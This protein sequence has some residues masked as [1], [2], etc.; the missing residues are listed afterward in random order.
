MSHDKPKT[1]AVL[2]LALA[3]CATTA[4][5]Q[6]TFGQ[7]RAVQAA[8]QPWMNRAL[9][10]DQRA[11][12]VLKELTLDEKIQMVHGSGRAPPASNGG[13][14]YVPGVKRLGL[15]DLNSADST[16]GVTGGAA[17]SRYSTLMPS[18]LAAAASWDTKAAYDYGA[19]IGRELRAQGY[20]VSLAGG[21]NIMR[22][23]RNGRSFEYLAEDPI[24]SGKLVGQTIRG[25]QDQKI[26]GDIKHYAVND[27]E[28]GRYTGSV[29]LD[30][31]SLRESDL[32][33]F[34][35]GVKEGQPGMAMCSYNRVNGDWACEN[36]YLLN[37]TLKRDW[38][39]KG[40]VISD[41]NGTH[42]TVKAALAGLDQQQPGADFF[43]EP[44]KQ[45]AQS[46]PVMAARVDDMVRRILRSEFATG[47]VDEP[48][49][50]Q[51]VDV[52]GGLDI[53][54]RIATVSTVLLK[55]GGALP[56]SRQARSIVV[57][58]SHADV[59]VLT[60]GGSA[61]V[62]PPGGN[63]APPAPGTPL[64]MFQ[65]PPVWYPSSPLKAMRAKATAT[66]LSYLSGADVAAAAA[67]AARADLAVVFANQPSA[68]GADHADLSL[69]DNQDALIAAVAAANPRTVVVL[70]TGGPVT[71]PWIDKVSAVVEAWYPGA[72]GGEAIADLLFA[73]ANFSARLPV[74]FPRAEADLPNPVLPGST[75]KPEPIPP[76]TPGGPPR[77][78][79]YPLFDIV[80]PEKANVGYKWYDATGKTPLF[81]FGHGLSYT[82]FGYSDLTV[83]Q[84]HVTF[85]VKNTGSR[86]GE[87]TAQV[88][89]RVPDPL[90][91]PRRLVVWAK[92]SLQPGESKTVTV[93]LEALHLSI[94]D[95]KKHGWRMPAGRYGVFVGASSRD[96][97]LTGQF[98][99]KAGG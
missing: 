9:S 11:D 13:A 46:D 16:V 41:W 25:L 30:E 31:R 52:M 64:D 66:Q 24:L 45:A 97:P 14:G 80:Y 10:A 59:G 70:E 61:Q 57:I 77:R 35:I 18:T 50:P 89:A 63:A 39:F 95:V 6:E 75:L 96:T 98:T 5:A 29:N 67:A 34:E 53:A 62:D 15:P 69:P 32:L 20:N 36:D 87:E 83:A 12:L 82:T 28:T 76:A 40:F 74:T 65:R 81:P 17:R 1:C 4:L 42:S 47:I 92:V 86:A 73:D 33:A 68:E 44:L 56:L 19:L 43:G 72:R 48:P 99:A 51:V 8:P 49:V 54:Q 84:D 26:L 7:N 85:T 27:Q 22:E 2:G 93:P 71:M 78:P 91:P 23:P 60:G 90:A 38:G 88:Y 58:G 55:N 37:Q 94:F 3:L 79:V 21:T